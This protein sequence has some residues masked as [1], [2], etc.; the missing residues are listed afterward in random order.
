MARRVEDLRVAFQAMSGPD[1]RD[2]WWA[3]APPSDPPAA[4]RPRVDPDV[5]AGVQ[6]AADA[7]R[8]AGYQPARA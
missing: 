4:T 7:L 1:P 5:A 8:D 3:P 6:Q 2:P